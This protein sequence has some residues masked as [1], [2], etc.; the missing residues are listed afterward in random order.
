M[1]SRQ[2]YQMTQWGTD[3]FFFPPCLSNLRSGACNLV[4]RATHP[5]LF[6]EWLFEPGKNEIVMIYMLIPPPPAPPPPPAQNKFY[7][8]WAGFWFDCL[9][10]MFHS[11]SNELIWKG[12]PGGSEV[13]ASAWNAGD[14]GSIPGLGRSPGAGNGNPLQYACLE[15]PVEGGAW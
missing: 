3:F 13:K 9:L 8:S 1:S 2:K 6:C 11:V 10:V 7:K 14:P 15:N 5:K 4:Y 12:F